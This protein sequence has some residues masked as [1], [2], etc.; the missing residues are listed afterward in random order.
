MQTEINCKHVRY[1]EEDGI[2]ICSDCCCEFD[3]LDF[4]QE[5][6]F[7]GSADSRS[8][9][10]PSRCHKPSVCRGGIEKVFVDA[11]TNFSDS[12]KNQTE[13]RYKKIVGINT[14][15]GSGRKAIVAACLLY[16]L[17]ENGD[18][19]TADEIGSMFS[20]SKTQMSEGLAKYYESYPED[21]SSSLKP[22]DLVLRIMRLTGIP[23]SYHTD[24]LSIAKKLDNVS[25]VLN[26]SSPQAVAAS[27]IYLYVCSDE[28]LKEKM[29]LTKKSFSMK[30]GLSEITITKLVKEASRLMNIEVKV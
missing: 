17:R 22:H 30:A 20:L 29:G 3:R 8:T 5:W 15:R 10:D 6:R 2:F 27:I 28:R 24:I 9:T 18:C 26:H 1:M 23:T 21:R 11:K 13:I 12:I 14:M 16:V 7:Y 19:R 25:R 4:D